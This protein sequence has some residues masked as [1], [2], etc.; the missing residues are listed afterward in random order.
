MA[1]TLLW[2]GLA[3]LV[4]VGILLGRSLMAPAKP[5]VVAQTIEGSE[6]RFDPE[7]L[8]VNVG[9]TVRIT[10][11]NVGILEHDWSVPDLDVTTATIN[12]GQEA[13]VEFRPQRRGTYEMI[14]TVPGHR[15]LGMRGTL[16]VQ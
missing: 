10:F 1:R 14:C 8:R 7:E 15:E 5:G 6:Y 13:T 2:G 16:I 3:L 9:E 11:R 4:L 12:A